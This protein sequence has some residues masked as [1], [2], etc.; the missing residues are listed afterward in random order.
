MTLLHSQL[1]TTLRVCCKVQK[2][3]QLSVSGPLIG[4]NF[5]PYIQSQRTDLYN[6]YVNELLKVKRFVNFNDHMGLF[7]CIS[8]ICIKI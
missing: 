5:G 2:D 4:G 3:M 1:S 7:V 8:Q 6:K